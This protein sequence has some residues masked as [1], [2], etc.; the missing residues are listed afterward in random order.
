MRNVFKWL[1]G[2]EK[3]QALLIVMGLLGVG[4]VTITVLLNHSIGGLYSVRIHEKEMKEYYATDAGVEYVLWQLSSGSLELEEGEEI[5]V[6]EFVLNNATVNAS[7]QRIPGTD[8]PSYRILST[9][10]GQTSGTTIDTYVYIGNLLFTYGLSS[11]GDIT[12]G[13]DCTVI[14]DIYFDGTLTTGSG[15]SLTGN[16]TEGGL[17]Y[18]SELE[19]DSFGAI[20]M[21]EAMAGGTC[22][23]DYTIGA[24]TGY[25]ELGPLY[26]TGNLNIGSGN[27]VNLTGTLYV[28]GSID[29]DQD[30]DFVGSGS[31]VAVGDIYLAKLPSFGVDGSTIIAS[32]TGDI[33]FKKEAEVTAVIYAPNGTVA[34]SKD[35]VITGSVVAAT[36]TSDKDST[37]DFEASV[38]QDIAL[39]G[40]GVHVGGWQID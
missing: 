21:D 16:V 36:I 23:G 26:I 4:A 32:L 30:S 19:N 12:L 15:F 10:T 8:L 24:G 31:I 18:P 13:K 20:Y 37:F 28:E 35:A 3:G 25:V 5:Y 29:I 34:F 22:T 7:V 27:T 39:P 38:S 1:P 11:D 2:G 17:D 14:G 6:P 33:T 40:G 9:A